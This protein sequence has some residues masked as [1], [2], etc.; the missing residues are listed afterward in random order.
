MLLLPSKAAATFRRVLANIHRNLASTARVRATEEFVAFVF[1]A[2]RL[3]K[4]RRVLP[5]ES[6]MRGARA[7]YSPRV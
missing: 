5:P 3:E 4:F 1:S 7:R 6:A 2:R